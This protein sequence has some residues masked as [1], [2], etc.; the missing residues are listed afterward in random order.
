MNARDTLAGCS[1]SPLPGDEGELVL[2]P[3]PFWAVG[4]LLCEDE[5]DD[6]GAQGVRVPSVEFGL[7]DTPPELPK[8]IFFELLPTHLRLA[9][10]CS[11]PRLGNDLV[12]F[13]RVQLRAS[14]VKVR[15][16]KYTAKAEVTRG[17][18]RCTVK[19]RVYRAEGGVLA[20][21]AQRQQGDVVFFM[22]VYRALVRFLQARHEVLGTFG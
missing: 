17:D 1:T 18:G 21:E 16:G 6:A 14:N 20:M 9:S 5:Q 22:N 10:D 3:P 2:P 15:P 4:D 19:L 12:D 13:L 8:A 7:A 11:A